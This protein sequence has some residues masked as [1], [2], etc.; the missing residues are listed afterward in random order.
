M[1]ANV[2]DTDSIPGWED[3]TRRGAAKPV[4]HSCWACALE[5]GSH[6][7]W[8]PHPLEPMLCNKRSRRNYRGAPAHL[9]QRKSHAAHPAQPRKRF[10]LPMQGH[11]FDPWSGTKIP[12]AA[13]QLSLHAWQWRLSKIKCTWEPQAQD[14]SCVLKPTMWAGVI[15]PSSSCLWGHG[16]HETSTKMLIF[17]LLLLPWVINHPLSLTHETDLLNSYLASRIKSQTT[18]SW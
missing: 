16:A 14:S 8:G 10:H 4:C 17:W 1:P 15:W 9:N 6:T 12:H 3:P 13:G 2:G 18:C 5:P 11:G 7:C